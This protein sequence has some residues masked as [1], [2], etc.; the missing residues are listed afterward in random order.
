M[1]P[2]VCWATRRNLRDQAASN[3]AGVRSEQVL[4]ARRNLAE[5][6]IGWDNVL[7]GDGSRRQLRG[8]REI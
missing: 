2:D 6:R 4:T 1:S 8:R 7:D 3:P 5:H